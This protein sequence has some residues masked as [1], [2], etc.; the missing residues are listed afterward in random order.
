MFE[1]MTVKCPFCENGD[2]AT[3]YQPRTMVMR[4]SSCSAKTA[5]SPFF[6]DP[7]TKVL[8]EKCPICGKTKK[9]IEDAL[10]HGKE[11]SREDVLKRLREAGLDPSKL[12]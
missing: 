10:K 5:Y 7:V 4:R 1:K 12:K 9:E 11:P 3:L 6:K 8:S 2:I